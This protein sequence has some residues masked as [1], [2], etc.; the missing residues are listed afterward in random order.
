MLF[1]YNGEHKEYDSTIRGSLTLIL[2]GILYLR[3]WEK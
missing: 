3:S 2:G 1:A